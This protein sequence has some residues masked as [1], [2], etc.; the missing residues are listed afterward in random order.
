MGSMLSPCQFLSR[1][2]CQFRTTQ[3]WA[4]LAAR[5]ACQ[6]E[7]EGDKRE[8]DDVGGSICRGGDVGLSG[9]AVTVDAQEGRSVASVYESGSRKSISA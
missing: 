1:S 2:S 4:R 6:P 5:Y 8:V 9:A 7:G 3:R